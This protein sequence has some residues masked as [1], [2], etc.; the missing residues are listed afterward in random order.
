[1]TQDYKKCEWPDVV[2]CP[3]LNTEPGQSSR[4]IREKACQVIKVMHW[5][6]HHNVR[7][8]VHQLPGPDNTV[9]CSIWPQRVCVG[10]V[11]GTIRE[12]HAPRTECKCTPCTCS[13]SE[14]GPQATPS[15]WLVFSSGGKCI[16]AASTLEAAATDAALWASEHPDDEVFILPVLQ[17]IKVTGPRSVNINI[18]VD[19]I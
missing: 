7:E 8:C 1:M 12:E 19:P 16:N 9:I 2:G 4:C 17:A 15:Q 11:P 3:Y 6:C 5:V 18:K 14:G 10:V 13:K